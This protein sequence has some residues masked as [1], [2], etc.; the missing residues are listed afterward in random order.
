MPKQVNRERLEASLAALREFADEMGYWPSIRDWNAYAK[1]HDV[2]AAVTITRRMGMKWTDVGKYLGFAPLTEQDCIDA[3]R[4]AAAVY[5]GL[6]VGDYEK[7]R[8]NHPDRPN[9]NAMLLMF[10]TWNAAK[11]KAGISL[12]AP[13][14]HVISDED[15][16]RALK[17]C[18]EA[19]G[20]SFGMR[21]YR[22][23]RKE[24]PDQPSLAAICM[25][26]GAFNVAKQRAGLVTVPHGG[27][28]KS[29]NHRKM[30]GLARRDILL[31]WH[32]WRVSTG[33]ESKG[34]SLYVSVHR[35]RWCLAWP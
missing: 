3:L 35:W 16:I 10:G 26:F 5:P 21:Q 25:R 32:Q 34:C 13:H 23:W 20:P 12:Q 17:L 2:M 19:C 27:A 11:E 1:D 14:V 31:H 24:H 4:A 8:A 18:A 15:M 9:A 22:E 33:S 7:W 6:S 29:K 30:T 28:R